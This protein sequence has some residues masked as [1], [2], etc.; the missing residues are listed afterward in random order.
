MYN[1]ITVV[2]KMKKT[3]MYYYSCNFDIH[4]HYIIGY[5]SYM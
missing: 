3:S 4:T 1:N 2:L 5:Y